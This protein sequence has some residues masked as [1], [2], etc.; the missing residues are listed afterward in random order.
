MGQGERAQSNSIPN[1]W[2]CLSSLR[3]AMI[4]LCQAM[5][6]LSLAVSV[7]AQNVADPGV[8]EVPEIRWIQS[9]FDESREGY[10]SLRWHAVENVGWYQVI[11]SN[12]LSYYD[13]KLN[14]AFVSGLPDGEHAFE[15]QAFST[16]GE[17]IGASRVP[18][19]IA[20]NHWPLSQAIALLIVGL[21]IFLTMV[22]AIVI[23]SLRA[24]RET[25]GRG[26]LDRT[27]LDG[28]PEN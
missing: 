19:V 13:G 1:V 15:V 28:E 18:A 12:G 7:S 23:G 5:A 22:A 25:T 27:K 2:M 9:R 17:L 21:I 11:D 20:V 26:M 14:E 3:L 24:S 8:A 6:L 16:F 10:Q 4:L